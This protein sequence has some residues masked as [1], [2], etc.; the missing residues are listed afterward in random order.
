MQHSNT[1]YAYRFL[2]VGGI[3]F[4]FNYC[5]LLLL[6]HAFVIDKISAEAIAM[7]FS[8]HL[9]F[10]MHD[11]WT[12]KEE[13]RQA[14]TYFMDIRKRYG[15]YVVSNSF[16]AVLTIIMF[17]VLSRWL[18][19][20]LALGISALISMVWNFVANKLFIWRK[21]SDGAQEL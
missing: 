4:I 19:S 7:V 9:T 6:H 16:S 12:Y 5:L 10:F 21:P 3:A 8:V 20:L 2:V 11:R 18:P 14:G 1:Q 15:S 13:G 17:G